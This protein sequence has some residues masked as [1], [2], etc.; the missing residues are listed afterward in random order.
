LSSLHGLRFNVF[1][2]DRDALTAGPAVAFPPQHLH[3][4][5][6][7]GNRALD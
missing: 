5:D 1:T 3:L 7:E 6:Q 4:F 2:L